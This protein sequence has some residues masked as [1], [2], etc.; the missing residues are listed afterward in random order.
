MPRYARASPASRSA[1][2]ER[3]RAPHAADRAR[4]RA[5]TRSPPLAGG[6]RRPPPRR[7]RAAARRRRSSRRLL[8]STG[9]YHAR[10][11]AS[12]SA[13]PAKR[14]CV[15]SNAVRAPFAMSLRFFTVARMSSRRAMNS[16][17]GSAV[18]AASIVSWSLALSGATSAAGL[19]ASSRE[20][21]PSNAASIGAE[22]LRRVRAPR[23]V[24]LHRAERLL[25][26]REQRTR[27][28][29]FE[30]A[31]QRGERFA[32]LVADQFVGREAL[33]LVEQALRLR[34]DL[35]E[36]G[37]RSLVD[38]IGELGRHRIGHRLQVVRQQRDGAG[39][40]E[41]RRHAQRVR[42]ELLEQLG[43]VVDFDHDAARQR[44]ERNRV[45]LLARRRRWSRESPRWRSS[46]PARRACRRAS[47]WR[48]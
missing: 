13:S 6:R 48:P 31:D 17:A 45:D 1:G 42:I 12:P 5:P 27:L 32:K 11:W 33:H 24:L 43:D 8:A 28:E 40:R 36:D 23:K 44:R 25:H 7:T 3:H 37:L 10:I 30:R 14:A 21:T 39:E 22:G 41:L 2:R 18:T 29:G 16:S 26:R 38:E 34:F 35:Q 9:A 15:L 19:R 47:G 4:H 20:T 46:P